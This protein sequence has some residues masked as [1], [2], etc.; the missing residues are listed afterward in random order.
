MAERANAGLEQLLKTGLVDSKRVAAIGFCFGG[1]TAQALAYS[2]APLAGIVSFHGGRVHR[3]AVEADDARE[4]SAAVGQCLRGRAAEAETDRGHFFRIDEAR[5]QKLLEPGVRPFGHERLSVELAR[6]RSR[7]FRVL[8]DD[9]LSVHVH[10]EGDVAHRGELLR[11]PFREGVEPPPFGNH[12]D[13]GTLPLR[14]RRVVVRQKA[15]Q[16][17]ARVLVHDGL[18]DDL[19]EGGVR[20]EERG[21]GDSEPLKRFHTENVSNPGTVTQ[22]GPAGTGP[23]RDSPDPG[24]ELFDERDVLLHRVVLRQSLALRPRVV[25]RAALQVEH[26]R[27]RAGDVPFRGLLVERVEVEK[28]VVGRAFRKF[29]DARLRL[30]ELVRDGVLLCSHDVSSCLF[31][32]IIAARGVHNPAVR[33]ALLQMNLAWEDWQANHARAANLL[34]RAADGGADLALLPEMFATGFSMDGAKIAQPPG[35]STERWLQSMARALSLH[36]IA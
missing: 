28:L 24:F 26:P 3:P 25:L 13:S 19:R 2:G 1:S 8:G 33:T 12:E 21:G 6:E 16:L 4:R 35:G 34:E 30:V 20:G 14:G 9:P 32:R 29:L 5:L 23:T 7:L 17:R 27:P 10:G 18:R 31:G 15:F 22:R 36:I 11:A